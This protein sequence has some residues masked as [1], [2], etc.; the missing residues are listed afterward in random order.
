MFYHDLNSH[1]V[2]TANRYKQ[3]YYCALLSNEK[4]AIFLL[5]NT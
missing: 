2:F 5:N 4:Y 1:Q 3:I